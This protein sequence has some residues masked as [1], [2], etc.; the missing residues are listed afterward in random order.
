MTDVTK[1]I[2]IGG[3]W[4]VGHSS[5]EV[6]NPATGEVVS[7]QAEAGRDEAREAI[8]AASGALG[9]WRGTSGFE[10]S[11]ILGRVAALL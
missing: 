4:R 11:A 6:K 2:L 3:E 9:G 5:R 8:D 7:Q 1:S 10:R